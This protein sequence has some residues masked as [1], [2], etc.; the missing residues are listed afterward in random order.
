MENIGLIFQTLV[1]ACPSSCAARFSSLMFID[2]SKVLEYTLPTHQL[3][4]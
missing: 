4:N 1:S 3:V 2:K